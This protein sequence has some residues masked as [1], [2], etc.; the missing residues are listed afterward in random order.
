MTVA[1]GQHTR[2]RLRRWAKWLVVGGVVAFAVIQI[3]P[4]D[5]TNPPVEEV[6]PA[7]AEVQAVLDRVC[8]D[9]HSNNSVWP[10]YSRIA[11]ISWLVAHDVEEGRAELNFSTWNAYDAEERAEA[12]EHIWEETAEGEMPPPYYTLMHAQAALSDAD[13]G[14]LR[15]WTGG[16]SEVESGED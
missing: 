9:C 6:M 4:V 7:P 10:W 3:I 15:A 16:S 12:L 1:N 13:I 2:S 14:A 8:A 5:R 11:P